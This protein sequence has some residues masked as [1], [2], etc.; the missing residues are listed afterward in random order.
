MGM[1]ARDTTSDDFESIYREH[2]RFVL[3]AARAF[4]VPALMVEDVAQDVFVTIY[5]KRES[6]DQTESL[7]PLLYA[8][9]RRTAFRYRRTI[10]RT[11]RRRE[12]LEPFTVVASEGDEDAPRW[13]RRFLATLEPEQRETLILAEL[14]GMTGSEIAEAQGVPLNTAYSRLRLARRRLAELARSPDHA[15]MLLKTVREPP[16]SRPRQARIWAALLPALH[17]AGSVS[18]GLGAAAWVMAGLVLGGVAIQ[19]VL[20]AP[21]AQGPELEATSKTTRL[22]AVRSEAGLARAGTP[23]VHVPVAEGMQVASTTSVASAAVGPRKP[24]RK[25]SRPPSSIDASTDTLSSELLLINAAQRSLAGGDASAALRE[26]AVHEKRFPAG[27]LADVRAVHRVSALRALGRDEEADATAMA[28]HCRHPESNV[29]RTLP[30][31]SSGRSRCRD[32]SGAQAENP[33]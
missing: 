19:A 16:P 7:R 20:P 14:L 26:L 29:V 12:A 28:A 27:Q 3:G 30:E 25:E 32:G 5:R 11:A 21:A 17:S 31:N 18:A 10:A 8:V 15:R 2:V 22:E 33:G 1:P 4:G 24:P 13:L 23:V 6:L 9:T